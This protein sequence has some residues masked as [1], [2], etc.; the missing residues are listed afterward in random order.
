MRRSLWLRVGIVLVVL[1]TIAGARVAS[2]RRTDNASSQVVDVPPGDPGPAEIGA[3]DAEAEEG[4]GGELVPEEGSAREEGDEILQQQDWFYSQRAYPGPTIPPGALAQARA[5]A[6]ALARRDSGRAAPTATLTW[7]SFGPA[8]IKTTSVPQ[9]FDGPAP[10]AGRVT[11]VAHD[12]TDAA[13]AYLGSAGGGVWKTTNSGGNWTPLFDKEKS[14][15]IGA[16]AVDPQS[17]STVYVGTGENNRNT[18]AYFGAGILRSTN[19]GTSWAKIGGST[20]TNCYVGS[21][22]VS[23]TS[24]TTL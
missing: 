19:G 20:F 17:S 23:P 3:S 14:L 15:S 1:A 13:T 10:Y 2:G 12:P 16:I 9:D 7:T 22:I 18:D 8:P 5:E 4:E 24:S 21:L 11:A 6:T